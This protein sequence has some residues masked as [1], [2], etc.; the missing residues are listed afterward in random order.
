MFG[1]AGNPKGYSQ[2]VSHACIIHVCHTG[3]E[4]ATTHWYSPTA[5][6][7]QSAALITKA[8][9]L[10]ERKKLP[11]NTP[12]IPPADLLLC[13]GRR[14]AVRSTKHRRAADTGPPRSVTDARE[15]GIGTVAAEAAERFTP[16][17]IVY[18]TYPQN[19][20][21][22]MGVQRTEVS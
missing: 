13:S 11:Q 17:P 16:K 15:R 9:T 18:E 14:R 7:K 10:I 2:A 8:T 19:R 6:D 21:G 20:A 5:P 22:G 1:W 4:T 12:T 3:Y